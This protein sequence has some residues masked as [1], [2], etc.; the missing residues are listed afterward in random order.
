MCA[1]V[2]QEDPVGVAVE[3]QADVCPRCEDP[4]PEV[5]QVRRL[6]GIG[7]VVRERPVEFGEQHLEFDG[8]GLEHGRN[9]EA[10]HAVRRVGH[11]PER[12]EHG[13]VDEGTD[14]PGELVEELDGRDGAGPARVGHADTTEHVVAYE[15][16]SRVDPDWSG[17][18][19]AHLD[20]VVPGGVVAGREHRPGDPEVAGGEVEHVG[21]R[22]ADVEDVEALGGDAVGEGR[23]EALAAR[24]HVAGD[25]HRGRLRLLGPD[26]PGIRPA[27]GAGQVDVELLGHEATHVVCLEHRRRITHR[28]TRYR[29]LPLSP[30]APAGRRRPGSGPVGPVGG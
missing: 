21:R 1:F 28:C 3:C 19:E 11:H 17:V 23:R 16:E 15:A 2:D 14:V 5:D 20:A 7:G 10:A 8:Q 27:D 9:H 6:E 25:G 4:V 18:R 26:Q 29:G 30:V 12:A 13:R 24:A 22:Q